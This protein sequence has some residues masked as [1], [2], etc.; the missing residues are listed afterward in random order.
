MICD[1]CNKEEY[2][3]TKLALRRKEDHVAVETLCLCKDC[4]ESF[5]KVYCNPEKMELVEVEE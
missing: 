4:A 1:M 3:V 5:L 2:T